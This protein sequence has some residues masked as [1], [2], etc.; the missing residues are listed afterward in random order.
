VEC[1]L[2]AVR[3]ANTEAVPLQPIAILPGINPTQ[4]GMK[5]MNDLIGQLIMDLQEGIVG[6]DLFLD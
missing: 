1:H 5:M 3:E 2:Q 6:Q 4:V